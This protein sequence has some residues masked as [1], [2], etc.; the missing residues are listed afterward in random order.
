MKR[1]KLKSKEEKDVTNGVSMADIYRAMRND[2]VGCPLMHKAEVKYKGGGSDHF[3][4]FWMGREDYIGLHSTG[5]GSQI[6]PA[7]EHGTKWT[8][9]EYG[10]KTITKMLDDALKGEF[11]DPDFEF[12]RKKKK[13]RAAGKEEFYMVPVGYILHGKKYGGGKTK[14]KKFGSKKAKLKKPILKQRK[15]KLKKRR[16]SK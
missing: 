8:S 6:S 5:G 16:V 10:A 2:F 11:L 4:F 13:V 1:K 12:V 3:Y 14:L 15:P 9:K 7:V